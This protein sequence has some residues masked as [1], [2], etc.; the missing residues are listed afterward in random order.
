MRYRSSI[1]LSFCLPNY[2]TTCPKCLLSSPYNI[3]GLH[4]EIQTVRNVQSG[5]ALR[6][7]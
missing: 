2:L 1:I 3:F 4:L 6:R 5:T 7:F